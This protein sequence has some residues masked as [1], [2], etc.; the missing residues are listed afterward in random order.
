MIDE[1]KIMEYRD[2]IVNKVSEQGYADDEELMQN[3][4]WAFSTALFAAVAKNLSTDITI[5]LCK[6][7]VKYFT[8]DYYG[9]HIVID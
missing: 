4:A 5:A 8:D 2:S 6:E 7:R 3:I 1:I 9:D